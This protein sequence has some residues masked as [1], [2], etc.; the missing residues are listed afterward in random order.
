MPIWICYEMNKKVST[1]PFLLEHFLSPEV[2]H[3]CEFEIPRDETWVSTWIAQT[4]VLKPATAVFA[5]TRY[6]HHELF[7]IKMTRSPTEIPGQT[8]QDFIKAE[9]AYAE[10]YFSREPVQEYLKRLDRERQNKNHSVP[11]RSSTCKLF[12]W[13]IDDKQNIHLCKFV[14]NTRG[15]E[16]WDMYPPSQRRYNSI[17]NE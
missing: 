9:E 1:D 11:T 6:H 13:N 17:R 8:W 4:D 14:S 5:S 16:K 10:S 3:Q 2:I 15:Q 7:I 12:E